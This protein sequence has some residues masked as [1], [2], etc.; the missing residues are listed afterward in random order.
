MHAYCTSHVLSSVSTVLTKLIYFNMWNFTLIFNV[1][2]LY[3]IQ[4]SWPFKMM[5]CIVLFELGLNATFSISF[6][7]V[8]DSGQVIHYPNNILHII[9]S[10]RRV[11]YTQ[12]FGGGSA[13]IFMWLALYWWVCCYWCSFSR[14][15][16]VCN[17]QLHYSKKSLHWNCQSVVSFVDVIQKLFCEN[18]VFCWPLY[19][20]ALTCWWWKKCV[21]LNIKL[22]VT[23]VS[24]VCRL[25]GC[26]MGRWCRLTCL[27]LAQFLKTDKIRSPVICWNTND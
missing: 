27:S 16:T 8:H 23:H 5:S 12:N 7:E 9:H 1:W 10:V 20:T 6:S 18:E 25:S 14:T 22:E 13:C 19:H 24:Q 11:R 3:T 4:S 26:D 21:D 17:R 2:M 15:N